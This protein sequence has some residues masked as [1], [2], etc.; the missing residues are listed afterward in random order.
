[1]DQFKYTFKGAFDF[2]D[3]ARGVLEFKGCLGHL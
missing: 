2:S 1:M 3:S